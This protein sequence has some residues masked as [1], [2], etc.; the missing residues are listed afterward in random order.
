LDGWWCL[1]SGGS[2]TGDG[3]LVTAGMGL[4]LLEEG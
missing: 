3:A 4:Q 2:G 1:R